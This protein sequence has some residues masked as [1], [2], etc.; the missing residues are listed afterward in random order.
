MRLLY[1][2]LTRARNRCYLV[3]ARYSYY[4]Q[5][6]PTSL[7]WVMQRKG[8]LPTDPVGE[9]KG[10][11]PDWSAPWQEIKQLADSQCSGGEA[12]AIADLPPAQRGEKWIQEAKSSAAI[13][14]RE[15]DRNEIKPAWYLTSFTGISNKI[16]ADQAEARIGPAHPNDEDEL[17]PD[18]DSAS[19]GPV[20]ANAGTAQPASGIFALPAGMRTGDCLHKI[21]EQ[22]DFQNPAAP[23]TQQ[24]IRQHLESAGI[25]MAA[26]GGA[27]QK[28]LERICDLPLPHGDGV[29]TLAEVPAKERLA[30]LEFHFPTA[31]FR[32]PQLMEAIR[33]P[34]R[35][36]AQAAAP[37]NRP[38][39][40]F[41]KGF[42][43]LVFAFQGRFHIVDWKSNL[44]GLSTADYNQEALKEKI[45]EEYYDLQYHIYTVAL[46][47][48]LRQRLRDYDYEKHFGGVHYVFLRGLD[49]AQPANGVFH[50][51]PPKA[52]I[53]ILSQILQPTLA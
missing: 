48:F 45:Q 46:D 7:A 2:A 4:A 42:M 14:A 5:N 24:L 38:L 36:G 40:A 29:F 6:N 3:S 49:A 44:L 15:C 19:G 12:I 17:M 25:S 20:Q 51:R 35:N 31:A 16:A 13:V 33:G 34:G 50:D 18:R 1:V 32:G 37:G 21:L 26:H 10:L 53:E 22:Y 11:K 43:D 27:V 28:M 23:K 41:M 8:D 52:T 30:E 9:L 39:S 47:K